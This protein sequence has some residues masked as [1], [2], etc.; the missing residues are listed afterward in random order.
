MIVLDTNVLS[1]EIRPLPDAAVHRWIQQQ[2]AGGLFTTAICH[3]EILLG[4]ALLPD[5]RRKVDLAGA[6]QHIFALFAGRVPPFDSAAAEAYSSIVSHR[7]QLGRPIN[8]FDAQIAAIARSRGFAVATRN[9][10]D[11]QDAGV[12]LIDPWK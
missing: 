4:V 7:R 12:A 10:A 9:V 2:P 11:F 1:E 8:D 5:G 6:A 3:A